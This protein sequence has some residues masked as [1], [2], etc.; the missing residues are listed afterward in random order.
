MGYGGYS[1]GQQVADQLTDFERALRSLP[2]EQADDT[3][4]ILEKL[5]RN[6]VRNP[7]EAKFRQIKLSNRKIAETITDVPGAVDVLRNMG[8]V[9][10]PGDDGPTLVLPDG[11]RL[12]FETEV[13]KLI[14]IKDF[15]KKTREKAKL[16][17]RREDLAAA[18]P[19]KRAIMEQL[20]LDRRE[21]ATR[22]PAVASHS[23]KLGDGP[24]IMRA[25]DIGIGQSA[26]G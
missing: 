19:E 8:W 9:D 3:L 23:K 18:D 10:G 7:R 26:G 24:N 1:P 13:V 5:T 16:N 22:G 15:Y 4:E 2:L 17:Q 11:V 14:D 12:A 6:V 25:G 20:E 21:T